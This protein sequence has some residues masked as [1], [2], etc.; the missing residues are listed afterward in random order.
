MRSL[1][2]EV[3]GSNKSDLSDD[4]DYS[5]AFVGGIVGAR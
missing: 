2:S 5:A 1:E 4:V 3:E